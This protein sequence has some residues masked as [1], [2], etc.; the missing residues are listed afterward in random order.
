[1]T[2]RDRWLEE[3]ETQE[4][5]RALKTRCD[6]LVLTLLNQ[7]QNSSDPKIV[8]VGLEIALIKDLTGRIKNGKQS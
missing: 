1:M 7:A 8:K 4:V 6:N 3:P 5:L 2:E